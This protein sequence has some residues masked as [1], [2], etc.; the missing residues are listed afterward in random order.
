MKGGFRHDISQRR[1]LRHRSVLLKSYGIY[2]L[3]A[4]Y[5]GFGIWCLNNWVHPPEYRT[6][7]EM[8]SKSSHLI[9][10]YMQRGRRS[11]C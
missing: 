6:E 7:E 8:E 5:L 10:S 4:F 2:T 11:F 3:S 9:S 1:V